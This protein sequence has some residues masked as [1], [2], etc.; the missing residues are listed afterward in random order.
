[1]LIQ[2]LLVVLIIGML[3]AGPSVGDV[4]TLAG[5]IVV[6][7]ILVWYS[8][9][10][11]GGIADLLLGDMSSRKVEQTYSLAQKYETDHNY[12]AAIDEY[13]L[14]IRKN[15]KDPTPRMKLANLYYHLGDY[16]NCLVYMNDALH[17]SKRM[18][19]ENRCT[20]ANRIADLYLQHKGDSASAV[21]V[22]KQIVDGFPTTKYAEYA[23]DRISQIEGNDSF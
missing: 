13:L 7:I 6:F 19:P 17:V 22:L 5:V 15:K 3:I 9:R 8:R 11:L 2:M 16:D 14:A 12:D 18:S 21:A 23:R 10:L 4:W 20:L 1:M